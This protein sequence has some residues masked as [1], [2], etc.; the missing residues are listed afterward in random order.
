MK[1]SMM[2]NSTTAIAAPYP[3]RNPYSE[4]AFSNM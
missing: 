1:P 2:R 3:M 4:S